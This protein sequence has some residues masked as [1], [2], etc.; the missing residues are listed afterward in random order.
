SLQTS[1]QL[2]DFGDQLPLGAVAGQRAGIES[3]QINIVFLAQVGS[4]MLKLESFFGECQLK[5]TLFFLGS[6]ALWAKLFDGF[7]DFC[8]LHG[9]SAIALPSRLE[10]FIESLQ[11]VAI[12]VQ[13]FLEA[14]N[15]RFD[16]RAAHLSIG[17]PCFARR[18]VLRRLFLEL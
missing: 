10:L 7:A 12:S 3:F 13:S 11:L 4:E 8:E 5:T 2:I 15:R 16:L 1:T 9:Q 14:D 18:N 6:F 17:E